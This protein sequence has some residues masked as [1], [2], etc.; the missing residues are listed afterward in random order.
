MRPACRRRK[1]EIR[2]DVTI[3]GLITPAGRNESH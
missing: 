3:E 1:R 2:G